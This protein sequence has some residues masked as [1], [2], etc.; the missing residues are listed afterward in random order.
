[1][2]DLEMAITEAKYLVARYDR[3]TDGDGAEIDMR[4]DEATAVKVL[5]RLAIEMTEARDLLKRLHPELHDA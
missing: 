3:D 5:I 1:M 4:S 2:M